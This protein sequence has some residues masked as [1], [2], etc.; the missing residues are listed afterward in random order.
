M[1]DIRKNCEYFRSDIPSIPVDL[2]N[3]AVFAFHKEDKMIVLANFSE[4]EQWV[5]TH[6]F[7]WF[8]LNEKLTDAVSGR[9]I[10]LGDGNILLGPYE[11]LWFM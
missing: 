9:K 4:H 1:I 10:N 3:K 5:D 8:G 2:N 11:Y 7:D 6:R